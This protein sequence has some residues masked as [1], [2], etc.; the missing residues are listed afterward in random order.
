[1]QM[2]KDLEKALRFPEG[3]Y[4]KNYREQEEHTNRKVRRH[5]SNTVN[6]FVILG[7]LTVILAVVILNLWSSVQLQAKNRSR[8]YACAAKQ[9]IGRGSA[10]C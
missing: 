10:H 8:I 9:D 3:A 4:I 5:G 7:V 1:M 2:R 6:R